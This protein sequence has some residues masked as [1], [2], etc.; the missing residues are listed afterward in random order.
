MYMEFDPHAQCMGGFGQLYLSPLVCITIKYPFYFTPVSGS[1]VFSFTKSLIFVYIPH[2]HVYEMLILYTCSLNMF[3]KCEIFNRSSCLLNA[4][5]ATDL[6]K[7]ANAN[8]VKHIC[9]LK[10][11]S[12]QLNILSLLNRL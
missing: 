10:F 11:L 7:I 9:R 6:K 4:E 2:Q 5:S 3:T 1:G 12:I 8:I